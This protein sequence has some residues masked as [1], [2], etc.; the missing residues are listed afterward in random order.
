M[1]NQM[2][3]IKVIGFIILSIIGIILCFVLAINI[4]GH[5]SNVANGITGTEIK[6]IE[7]GMTL[8]QVISVLGKP[9]EIET[10]SG[11]HSLVSCKNP[12]LGLKIRVK[13][14]TDIVHI[15]DNFYDTCYC[16]DGYKESIQRMGKRVTL[17]YTKRPCLSLFIP[18]PMLWVH[19]DSNYRVWNVFAKRYKSP[20]DICIY[21]LSWKTDETTL[22]EI[23]GETDLFI[24]DELF[25]KCFKMEK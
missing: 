8:E 18:Y 3:T 1:I 16:C 4:F 22:E 21:S 5:K 17:T 23:S 6:R 11:Q 7:M 25:N 2:K 14:N 12:K 9:Y 19:L 15:V 24:N 20:D 13:E 10:S